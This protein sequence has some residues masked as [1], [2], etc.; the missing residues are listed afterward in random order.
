MKDLARGLECFRCRDRKLTQGTKPRTVNVQREHSNDANH[1]EPTQQTGAPVHAQVPKQWM[2]K[3]D[4]AAG[5]RAAEEVICG[6]QA[7][8]VHGVAERD[9]HKQTLHDDEDGGS[10]DGDADGGHDPM[11]GLA[12]RPG[13]EEETDGGTKGVGQGWNQAMLLDRQA[14]LGD[15]R[16]LVKV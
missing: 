5:Q 13:K 4:A 6:K 7:G 11:N 9:V 14:V 8:G 15:A 1:A 2:G 3:E 10:V 16:V 12:G